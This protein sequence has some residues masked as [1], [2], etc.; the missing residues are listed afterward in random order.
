MS[1]PRPFSRSTILSDGAHV[2]FERLGEATDGAIIDTRPLL[3]D[4]GGFPSAH[5]RFASDL[6]LP[7]EIDDPA[8]R[9]FT[10][11]AAASS[12]PV[13][14]GGHTVVSGGLYLLAEACWKGRDLNRRLHP[15]PFD[16][17]KEHS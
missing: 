11:A 10:R 8:W 6:L 16:P 12:I 17:D 4:P 15:D 14:L 3:S 2:F 7:D 13:L 5:D 9:A 1:P